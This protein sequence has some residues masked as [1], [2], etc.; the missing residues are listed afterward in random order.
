MIKIENT[1]DVYRYIK[2]IFEK[3]KSN[4]ISFR[5]LIENNYPKI[6]FKIDDYISK[7]FN[8]KY[9]NNPLLYT[10]LIARIGDYIEKNDNLTPE[11]VEMAF[12]DSEDYFSKKQT[13]VIP[14]YSNV[15]V[16][17]ETIR[18]NDDITICSK[19]Y[20]AK[21]LDKQSRTSIQENYHDCNIYAV[22]E[23]DGKHIDFISYNVARFLTKDLCILL[24]AI[25]G[26]VPGKHLIKYSFDKS[27]IDINERIF[28]KPMLVIDQNRIKAYK[29]NLKD[30]SSTSHK[31][32]PII[33]KTDINVSRLRTWYSK[34]VKRMPELGLYYD[35]YMNSQILHMITWLS[36]SICDD[37]PTNRFLKLIICYEMLLERK[38]DSQ[39]NKSI[40]S[41][42][43]E[44]ASLILNFTNK[45]ENIFSQRISS[46]YKIRSQIVH[47]GINARAPELC[48]L[49]FYLI[50]KLR[51][52]IDVLFLDKNISSIEKTEDFY[53]Y[54][55]KLQIDREKYLIRE[56]IHAL[57][58]LDKAP[59]LKALK[60]QMSI[61]YQKY[62]SSKWFYMKIQKN[63]GLYVLNDR[64][65]SKVISGLVETNIVYRKGRELS[66]TEIG[67]NLDVKK[68]NF[69]T[70]EDEILQHIK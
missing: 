54:L 51:K 2:P 52:I 19:D 33:R 58:I 48:N 57:R 34:L 12:K 4:G 11:I 20:L 25:T 28:N 9:S 45:E 50:E 40:T 27:I 39:N 26:F 43:V 1:Q 53:K 24:N 38:N 29:I 6:S 21:Y 35:Y 70:A 36:D 31:F 22:I 66:L 17:I 47:A 5:G 60:I 23:V 64:L 46:A 18:V 42:L 65:I 13:Y 62:N 15:P 49:Y 69:R 3:A 32:V 59:S 41:Q 8:H 37:D 61:N 10:D 16:N 55:D 14:I 44:S 67:K 56:I 68:I 30:S 63:D 7:R